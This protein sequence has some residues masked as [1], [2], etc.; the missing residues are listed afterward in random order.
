MH[1]DYHASIGSNYSTVC[2]LSEN[3]SCSKVFTS[4]YARIFSFLGVVP[5]GSAL[6]QPNAL[7]GAI[8]YA[9]FG[10]MYV[11]KN[12]FSCIGDVLLFL[13][14]A[15]MCLSAYLAYILYAVLEGICVVCISTY[16]CNFVL[17][18]TCLYYMKSS[19]ALEL[20]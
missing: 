8:Y 17:F 13:S 6:D 15:S 5:S 18:S 7:Y 9:F 12:K 19:G 3:I 1:V 2:D 16:L 11:L 10:I 4:E 14:A 20:S